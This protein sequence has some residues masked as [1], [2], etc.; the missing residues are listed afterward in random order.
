MNG[1]TVA[2]PKTVA[3]L[4]TEHFASV[5]RK[6]P[7]TL[8]ALHRLHVLHDFFFYFFPTRVSEFYNVPFSV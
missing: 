2:D 5:S 3:N 6:D 8:M 1:S 4:F 7:S